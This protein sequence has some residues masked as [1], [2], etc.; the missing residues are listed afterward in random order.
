MP[1]GRLG[2]RAGRPARHSP[3]ARDD[4]FRDDPAQPVLSFQSPPKT[5]ILPPRSNE[6]GTH[7]KRPVPRK[8]RLL[9][10]PQKNRENCQQKW[11]SY[12]ENP[13]T[14][15]NRKTHPHSPFVPPR[16]LRP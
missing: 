9:F 14:L 1:L 2:R 12:S 8:R 11:V 7:R 6:E 16:P 13:I 3:L 10:P 15:R 5:A 4:A